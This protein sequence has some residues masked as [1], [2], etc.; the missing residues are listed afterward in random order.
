MRVIITAIL[1]ILC[2]T[3][4]TGANVIDKRSSFTL[5]PTV[6]NP[7]PEY[8]KLLNHSIMFFE[9]QR[10]GKLPDDNRISWRHDSALT[11]GSDVDHDLSGGYYDAG[12]YLKFTFPLSYTT[13]MLCWG[14]TDYIHG[15]QLANQTKYLRDQVKWATDWLIKAHPSASTLFVQVG[16][17]EIDNESFGPDS[18]IKDPRPSYQINE[19]DFGTD[20]AAMAATAFA[21][22]S[23]FFNN[24]VDVTNE[25]HD[26][27]KYADTLLTHA[28][29]LY[30]AAR[31][32]LPY[33]RY[34]KSV[35]TMKHPLGY[36]DELLLAGVVLY[37]ATKQ[38]SYLDD[39]IEMYRETKGLNNHT[40]PLDWDNKWGAF[41]SLLA[42]A[43]LDYRDQ[44]EAFLVRAEAEMYLDGIVRGTTV[45]KTDGGL[46]FWDAYSTENS[47]SLAMST[48]FLLLSYSAKLLRPLA[49]TS[50]NKDA[51]LTKA[52]RYEDF[53]N[54]QIDYIFGKNP[55][56]Q[57]YVVGERSNSPKYPHS[58]PA[59]GFTSLKEALKHP[60][61]RSR[62]HT[63]Y[64][65][66]PSRND[67]FA[68]ARLDWS[69]TE[70]ALDYNA[71]YQNILA[72]QIMFHPEDPFYM[73]PNEKSSPYV[74][75][76]ENKATLPA[77][78]FALAIVLP[79]LVL[80]GVSIGAFI[81]IRRRQR[82]R[83]IQEEVIYAIHTAKNIYRPQRGIT[84]EEQIRPA[85][86]QLGFISDSGDQM[87]L[88][89]TIMTS[90]GGSTGVS[91]EKLDIPDQSKKMASSSTDNENRQY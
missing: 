70:V 17:V 57:H 61:D 73:S 85:A 87:P 43:T 40:E 63:I 28:T 60:Y 35:P 52:Q 32:I 33:S 62:A 42:E 13:F 39:T 58:A 66:G 54:G 30:S 90:G 27:K 81:L 83:K 74:D 56:N 67:S 51:L 15:Y 68:D 72:Y 34:H 38:Q 89:G 20:A 44:D 5:S 18:E 46:L 65:G 1:S 53:A 16:D 6:Q 9:A 14:G 55:I 12:D 88:N 59:S 77:W 84:A 2:Q 91:N 50:P 80:L 3:A 78:G 25:N 11:D 21:S 82:D 64:G 19:T 47:N 75:E 49:E 69:Q 24:L 45:N 41:Y 10:S 76:L 86:N 79:A 23:V 22:A 71:P 37:K 8:V 4:L 7:S 31:N 36:V 29:Q 26:D 48:S